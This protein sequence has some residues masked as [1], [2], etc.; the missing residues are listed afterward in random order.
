VSESFGEG[1]ATF[2][3]EAGEILADALAEAAPVGET[4]EL[5]ASMNYRVNSGRLEVGSADARG[6]IAAY[7]TRGTKPHPIDPVN[8]DAL[9]WVDAGGADV[10]AK[11]VDHPGTA[12]NPFHIEAWEAHRDEILLLYRDRVGAGSLAV[13]NPWRRRILNL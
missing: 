8:A 4:G 9:H 6:P 10:F 2:V 5:A 12:P 7:V 11:H 3:G 1:W 13:L